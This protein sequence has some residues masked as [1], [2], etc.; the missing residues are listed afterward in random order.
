MANQYA[1]IAFSEAAKAEQQRRGSRNS[2][3][4]MDQGPDTQHVFSAREIAF[5]AARDS[6]YIATVNSDGWPYV[7][8]RG[9]PS[10]FI[11]VLD[12]QRL[13]L[14]DYRGNRQYVTVGNLRDNAKVSMILMDYPNR[15]RLKLYGRVEI[16][17]DVALLAQLEDPSYRA[18]VERG[19]IIHLAAF[20]WNCPQ[21][22]T[23]RFS[24]DEWLARQAEL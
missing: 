11:K 4:R 12:S 16:C 19:F 3:Q 24:Q 18:V 22:I 14:A 10:G 9:G 23:P 17:E 2:Y 13:A 7:Q 21:H 1:Q 15:T 20:D 5:I 6:A 8:H